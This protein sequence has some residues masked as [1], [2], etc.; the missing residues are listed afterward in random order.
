MKFCVYCGNQLP[1]EASFCTKCGKQQPTST[2]QQQGIPN[3]QIKHEGLYDM[4]T[5]KLN[6][7]TGGKGSVRINLKMLFSEVFKKHSSDEAEQIFI[8]GT[9]YT[10]PKMEDVSEEWAKPWLFSRVLSYFLI[11]FAILIASA[12]VF[13]GV[14][15]VPGLMLVSALAVPFSAVVFYFEFNAYRNISIFTIIKIYFIGGAFSLLATM[16]LYQFA[17]YSDSNGINLWSAFVIGFVEEVGKMIIIL[18]FLNR[19]Q[20][21]FILNGILIGGAVGAGFATFETAGYI[22]YSGNAYL[23]TAVLRALTAI[24]GHLVWA[25]IT[26]GA[27]MLVKQYGRKID[28]TEIFS[29][30]FWIFFGLSIFLHAMWDW[31]TPFALLKLVILIIAAWIVLFV[32]MNAGINQ[33]KTFKQH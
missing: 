7:Y 1:V 29:G 17:I 22:F 28:A 24:G 27:L 14:L 3:Y 23:E 6:S 2:Q 12:Y 18:Y 15:A 13:G 19:L 4:A 25:A 21:N 31:S 20:N 33:V 10:T 8:A 9:H 5:G 30:R 11:V 16:L 32:L 26:G